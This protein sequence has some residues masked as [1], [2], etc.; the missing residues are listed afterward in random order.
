M[1]V[2]RFCC[3][4]PGCP[5]RTF[6][7]QFDPALPRSQWRTAETAALLIQLG[8]TAGGEGGARLAAQLGVPTSPDTVL[9]LLRRPVADEL[10]RPTVLGVDDLALRRGQRYATLL[11]DL[12]THDPV[13]LLEGRDA[14]TLAHWLRTHPG[15]QV[16]VP[17]PLRLPPN[18]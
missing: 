4:T 15:V 11:V 6:A 5:K 8:L 17:G 10:P 9:R 1:A 18:S 13:D 7:E 16:P 12:A 3:R 2:R 14:E